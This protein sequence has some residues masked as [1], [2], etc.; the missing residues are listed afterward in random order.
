MCN[1]LNYVSFSWKQFQFSISWSFR[2]FS[3]LLLY[4]LK[5]VIS[6]SKHSSCL[7]SSLNQALSHRI[8]ETYEVL[9]SKA[10][11]KPRSYQRACLGYPQLISVCKIFLPSNRPQNRSA[12][13]MLMSHFK[14]TFKSVHHYHPLDALT[15]FRITNDCLKLNIKIRARE[16]WCRMGPKIAFSFFFLI[17]LFLLLFATPVAWLTFNSL[18]FC[19]QS[20]LFENWQI[21]V[22]KVDRFQEVIYIF[23]MNKTSKSFGPTAKWTFWR[24]H[25]KLRRRRK[26]KPR[27]CTQINCFTTQ[28]FNSE[29]WIFKIH[30]QT[31]LL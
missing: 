28:M 15:S 2:Q 20:V 23:V 3:S 24:E 31:T 26:L 1:W 19:L 27:Q 16:K 22:E 21:A 25:I 4:K 6:N 7:G 11:M 18:L 12:E 8:S 17:F 9:T 5:P 30:D 13:N 14:Y 10:E 29:F